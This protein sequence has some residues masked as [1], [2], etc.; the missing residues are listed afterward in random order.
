M[1]TTRGL[2][3]TLGLT[4]PAG[5]GANPGGAR[6]PGNTGPTGPLKAPYDVPHDEIA[7]PVKKDKGLGDAELQKALKNLPSDPPKRAEALADLVTKVSD[8]AKRDPLVRALRDTIAKIQ[9]LMSDADAKKKID[10]AIDDLVSKGAK[11]ALMALLKAAVGKAPTKVDRDAPRKDGPNMPEKDLNEKIF[12]LPEIPLP[13]DKPPK[14]RRNSF[15]FV[16]LSKSY[17]PSKYFDFKL[18]TPE[19]FQVNGK[20]GAGWVVIASKDDFDKTS[21]RPTRLRDKRIDSKG[22][23]AMSLAAPDEPGRYVIFIVVG[24]GAENHPVEEFDV[25]Q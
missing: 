12:K 21:G 11:E 18:R 9:P 24:S 16:G 2:L 14:V 1:T 22:E 20:M 10:K 3:Q 15:E 6:P 13:F 7:A 17:K 19:W 8:T 5:A 23:V 25:T 4:T